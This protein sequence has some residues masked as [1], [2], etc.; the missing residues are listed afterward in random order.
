[1]TV[2]LAR[3]LFFFKKYLRFGAPVDNT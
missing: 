3:R 2:E 1:L